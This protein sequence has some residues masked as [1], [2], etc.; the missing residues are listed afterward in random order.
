MGEDA[1]MDRDSATRDVRDATAPRRSLRGGRRDRRR[2]SRTRRGKS[3]GEGGGDVEEEDEEEGRRE[4]APVKTKWSRTARTVDCSDAEREPPR[5]M[6]QS[7]ELLGRR[8]A[9]EG[10][11]TTDKDKRRE[12]R[13]AI[14]TSQRAVYK[15]RRRGTSTEGR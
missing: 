1:P 9:A 6:D 5:A 12:D 2:P 8:D 10:G 4:R 14:I 13:E 11:A 3:E 15:E 7:D